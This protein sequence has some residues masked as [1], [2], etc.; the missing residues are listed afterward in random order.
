MRRNTIL[1][2]EDDQGCR[3][4]IATILRDAGY[5]T[6]DV[7]RGS[8]AQ[9]AVRRVRPDL[10]ILDIDLPGL[11][12]YEVCSAL[13]A[14]FGERLPIIFISGTRAEPLDRVA[15][16]L[17]GGDEFVAKPFRGDDLLG[18]VRARLSA[19]DGLS[20]KPVE[21][22]FDLTPREVDVL[23]LLCAGRSPQDIAHELV[24]ARKTVSTHIQHILSK[25]NVHSQAQ[26]VSLALLSG[27]VHFTEH[28]SA[29][30]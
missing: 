2:A 6:V 26:A 16:R 19:A 13:R 28:A 14:E 5:D 29:S 7:A 12:G 9:A 17:I 8:D 23:R 18:A 30:A 11:T 15:V 24:L 25:L 27:L 22:S 4:L 20:A 1:I 10:V 3:S 21:S